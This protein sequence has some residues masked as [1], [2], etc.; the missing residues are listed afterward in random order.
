ML[1]KNVA[2]YDTTHYNMTYEATPH[3]FNLY[4]REVLSEAPGL[5]SRRRLRGIAL[6]SGE[7]RSQESG[8]SES[9]IHL[10]IHLKFWCRYIHT[11]IH[12]YIYKGTCVHAC[13][14]AHMHAHIH[15][16]IHTC[17]V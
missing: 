8:V 1:I 10:H 3:S 2:G 13:I 11:Y 17:I 14:H 16:Y 6:P 4:L 9:D 5:V 15:T 12:T 7:V